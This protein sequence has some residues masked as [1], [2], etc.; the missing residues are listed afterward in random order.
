MSFSRIFID[1]PVATSLVMAAILLSGIAAFIRLPVAA[2]P[3]VD[4]PTIQVN[5]SLP[6]ADPETMA[7]SVAAPLE[8][9][10]AQIAHLTQMTSTSILG[11]TSIGLQFDLDRD[12]DAAAQDV[13]AA[14]NAAAGQLPK[15]LPNPPQYNK[16]NPADPPILI[17]GIYSEVL[18]IDQV[19]DYADVTIAQQIAQIPGVGQVSVNGEQKPAVRVQID[20]AAI[21]TAGISL[22]D[23]RTVLAQATVNAPKGNISG[24]HQASTLAAND[25]LMKAADFNKVIVAY[26]NGAPVHISD[27]GRAIDGVENAQVAAWTSHHRGLT[28]SVSRQP[29]ANAIET[30]DLV[31]GRLA[32]L[33]KMLPPAITLIDLHDKTEMIRASVADIEFTLGVTVCLVIM[34]IFLFLRKVWATV[35]TGLAV[36]LSL[37]GT[38]GI[39]YLCGYSLDNLSLMALTIAVGFVVDDAIVMIENIVRHVE[40]GEPPYDAAVKGAREIG[41]TIVSITFSLIAVFIPLLLMGGMVGRLFHEFAVVL[42]AAVLISAFVSLTLTPT[43]CARL[44]GQEQDHHGAFYDA[45]DRFF[46]WLSESYARLLRRVLEHQRATL[47]TLGVTIA[48]TGVL[49]AV[50]PKGFFPQQ[51]TGLLIGSTEAAQDISFAEMLRKQE[52]ANEIVLSDP[53]VYNT[54][55]TMGAGSRGGNVANTGRIGIALKPFGER[56]VTADQVIARL[57]PKLAQIPGLNVRLVSSQDITVG[58]RAAKTQFQYTLQDQDV[59]ELNAWGK[60]MLA[61]LATIPQIQDVTTDQQ[62]AGARTVVKIDRDTASRLGVLPQQID[63]VLYDAFGQ[64]QVTTIFTQLNQY[65]VILEIEPRLQESAAALDKLYVR[66]VNGSQVPLSAFAA[67]ERATS[68]L[69]VS[70]Q[71]QF[72]AVTLSFNLAPGVAL[73]QAIDLVKA[74]ERELKM[75]AT[76]TPSF[77]GT[78]QAFQA[79]LKTMPWLIGA[80]LVA[81]YIVLGILYESYIHP[82]TILSTI[83]SAGVGALLMLR[84]FGYPLDM[85]GLIGIILLIG[86]VKKNAIMMID[87][88][89]EAERRE[90]LSP[91]DS[92]YRAATLRF[93]PIMMTTMSALFSG[94]PL[95]VMGGAGSE[96]RRPLGFAIVGGLILSQMLTLFTTPVVYLALDRFSAKGR[97]SR[98]QRLLAVEPSLS[99]GR[100]SDAAE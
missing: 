90:G 38:F 8:R 35:I 19:N 82:L 12:I 4:F 68:P 51:D 53:A 59:A 69:V 24:P 2:L 3:Q 57:K 91:R 25:Q 55:S 15:N 27:I 47:A 58:A 92:I 79:S 84:L 81:V 66:S 87:F 56:D 16:S 21:A 89:L 39:M 70:H 64:R 61:K 18:P 6:G 44:L 45:A 50:S 99:R 77:Q 98:L 41:F 97:G 26:R 75:P 1:R 78:A 63:D 62:D 46:A 5:A 29:G 43:M 14:I 83:P 40:A 94:I 80:A 95:M 13:S 37:V 49:F 7:S 88:A 52:M 73:S 9:Q 10:F 30:V 17:L 42:S 20:P 71:G 100:L 48:L 76:I 36:P 31:Y 86:I 93:R 74:A 72:P 34:V 32:Q 60:I 23:V 54:N 96:L 85:I 11:T 65:H 67:F 22:E 28:I 33:Q